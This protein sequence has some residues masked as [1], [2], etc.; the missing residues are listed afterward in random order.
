M[1]YEV[2]DQTTV[3]HSIKQINQTEDVLMMQPNDVVR[4]VSVALVRNECIGPFAISQGNC[5]YKNPLGDSL[6]PLLQLVNYCR[7]Q[8]VNIR[9]KRAL[10]A[11]THLQ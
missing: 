10:E 9:S 8:S 1:R 6:N 7:N 5:S 3:M 4:S 2:D 11:E